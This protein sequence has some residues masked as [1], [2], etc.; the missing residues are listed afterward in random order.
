MDSKYSRLPNSVHQSKSDPVNDRNE[1]ERTSTKNLFQTNF[2]SFFSRHFNST[3]E[4]SLSS[5]DD[6]QALLQKGDNDPIL[7]S[8]VGLRFWL[9]VDRN[10]CLD[11]STTN[12]WIH[13]VSMHGFVMYGFSNIVYPSDCDE[14]KEICDTFF[15]WKFILS[16]E[17]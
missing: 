12:T 11:S 13:D 5:S 9:I 10:D 1:N 3:D 17:V 7:P 4:G 14:S 15:V 16:L 2:K 6:F 8:L